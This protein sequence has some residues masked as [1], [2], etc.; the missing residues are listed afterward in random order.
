MPS[1]IIMLLIFGTFEYLCIFYCI[2]LLNKCMQV[3]GEKKPKQ[4]NKTPRGFI[5]GKEHIRYL[6]VPYILYY[7]NYFYGF[8]LLLQLFSD[9]TFAKSVKS[10]N[11][12]SLIKLHFLSNKYL[13]NNY[14]VSFNL[15]AFLPLYSPWICKY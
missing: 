10:T 5:L 4:W 9:K 3:Q 12:T 8:L 6:G 14:P 7:S 13:L 11:N 1:V 2:A 15:Q